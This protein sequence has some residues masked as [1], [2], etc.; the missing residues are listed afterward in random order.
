[1]RGAALPGHRRG[2]DHR[3]A[4]GDPRIEHFLLLELFLG[5][6]FAG[7]AARALGGNAGLDELRAERLHLILRCAAHVI[8]F[9][10]GA[11]S[12]RG[13]DGLQTRHAGTD[14]EHRRRANRAGGGG[15]H[16]K[17]FLQR[18]RR[19]EHRLVAGDG[20]LRRQR[21]HRLRARDARHQFHGKTRD[22]VAFEGAHEIV[23]RVGLHE[24][25]DHGSRFE[26]SDGARGPAAAR[27]AIRPRPRES[28]RRRVSS[29]SLYAL[30]VK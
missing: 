21:V 13:G 29:A 16:G 19:D 7:V 8:R 28:W 22:P 11:Q 10:Y 4:R 18:V 6:E 2:A 17:K 1:M 27:T 9:D 15:Q 26:R 25:Y 24:S 23:A 20:G 12:P 3:I 14:D 5:G 30:S